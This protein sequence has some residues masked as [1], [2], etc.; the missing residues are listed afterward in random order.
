[1]CVS[2]VPKGG[3]VFWSGLFWKILGHVGTRVSLFQFPPGVM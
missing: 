1:M 3:A 2:S